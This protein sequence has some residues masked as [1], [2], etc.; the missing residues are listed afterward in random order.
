MNIKLIKILKVLRE[1]TREWFE[2][3]LIKNLLGRTGKFLIRGIYWARWFRESFF[4]SI[5]YGC[6]ITSRKMSVKIN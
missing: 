5:P 1:E 6:I 2:H 3:L 4:F